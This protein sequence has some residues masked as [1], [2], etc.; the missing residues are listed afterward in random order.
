[1]VER[2]DKREHAKSGLVKMKA[3]GLDKNESPSCRREAARML[4]K[5]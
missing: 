1:M 5:C 3:P 4:L 2:L